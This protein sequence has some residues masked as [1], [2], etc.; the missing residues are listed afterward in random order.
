[1]KAWIEAARPRTLPLAL[2]CILMGCF[3]AYSDGEFNG[4][5]AG[6]SILT[7]ILLQVLSN[8][9][10]DYG[11]AVSGKDS[12]L[13]E[14]PRRAVH[15]GQITARA[16]QRAIILFSALSLIAGIALLYVALQNASTEVF[17]VFLG[18]GLACIAAAITYTAG[19]RP[20]GYVG[21][22]DLSVLIFFG[23]VG[24]LG[25]Y[26]LHTLSWNWDLLLPAT[27]CGLF[28][29]AVLNINNIRDI[30]SDRATGKNSIPV[31]LGRERAV[32]YHWLILLTGMACV[33]VYTFTEYSH[34]SQW[35]YVLSFPLFIWN[36][37]AVSR[38]KKAAQLDP[39]LKQMALSTLLFVVLF[40]AGL[41]L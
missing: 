7:T 20:Y 19:K 8:F 35:L 10:N 18:I 1:M 4:W 41:L 30:E 22:G 27:S 28:A 26:Y 33:T 32:K 21:L 9:A 38:L 14:G 39:Y 11:D 24:V 36:G 34:Y 5:I 29:V 23:W 37:L 16:M 13:R 31:R 12:D 2:S 15:G 6:L 25:T 40:G 3:L 17:W